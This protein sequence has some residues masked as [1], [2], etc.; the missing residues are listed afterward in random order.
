MVQKLTGDIRLQSVIK[1][2]PW[3]L[4]KLSGSKKIP[5]NTE[6]RYAMWKEAMVKGGLE[7]IE[8]IEVGSFYVP[9]SQLTDDV[10]QHIDASS[11]HIH[12]DKL[13]ESF[14]EG[15]EALLH[16]DKVLFLPMCCSEFGT[17]A[18]WEDVAAYRE[19]E[20]AMVWIGHPWIYMKYDDGWLYFT[21]YTE[22]EAD[23]AKVLY[24]IQPQKIAKAVKRA[25]PETEAFL[26][27]YNRYFGR[28]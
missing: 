4:F 13:W 17:L 18:E 1:I 25:K 16:D 5:R 6:K 8:P 20:W 11:H 2:I 15:G 24:A 3:N 21:D 28:K 19:S 14:G 23:K 9:V 7:S 27:R 12:P 10:L 22:G 26:E